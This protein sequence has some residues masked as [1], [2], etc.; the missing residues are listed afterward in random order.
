[1][2]RYPWIQR[3]PVR[4]LYLFKLRLPI[5]LVKLVWLE[6]VDRAGQLKKNIALMK[7]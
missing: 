7:I 6:I 1:M 2:S 5:F 3:F 4:P